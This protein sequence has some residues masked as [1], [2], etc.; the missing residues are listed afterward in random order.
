MCGG[1][2][3]EAAPYLKYGS[4]PDYDDDKT[5]KTESRPQSG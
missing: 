1:E 2:P 3:I 5:V 4:L